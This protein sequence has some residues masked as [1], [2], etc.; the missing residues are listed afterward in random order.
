MRSLVAVASRRQRHH[1]SDRDGP[2]Q[3]RRDDYSL[4]PLR[5]N[6]SVYGGAPE[7]TKAIST[8]DALFT[9]RASAAPSVAEATAT[10]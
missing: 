8:N 5:H 2:P 3:P 1:I 9:K 4:T 7:F 6:H 10:A